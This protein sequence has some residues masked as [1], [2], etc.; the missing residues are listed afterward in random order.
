MLGLNSYATYPT[1]RPT[2]R[3][4]AG[5]EFPHPTRAGPAPAGNKHLIAA[6][7]GPD[8]AKQHLLGHDPNS[9]TGN[10]HTAHNRGN[11]D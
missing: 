6:S 5:P 3:G 7:S 2:R 11:N 10:V 8:R 4:R 1:G 9:I